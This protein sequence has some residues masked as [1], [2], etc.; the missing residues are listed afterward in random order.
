MSAIDATCAVCVTRCHEYV[1]HDGACIAVR[2]RTT[3][4]WLDDH[5]ALD[6]RIALVPG[7][8]HGDR[9]GPWDL[10]IHVFGLQIRVG[11]V[12]AVVKAE[13]EI[14]THLAQLVH[15]GA[16]I[17]RVAAAGPGLSRPR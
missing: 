17:S 8:Y 15:Q 3:G 5:H 11:P 7:S 9:I 12:L 6:E 16:W 4:E 13:E 2:D 10:E 1:I 14:M